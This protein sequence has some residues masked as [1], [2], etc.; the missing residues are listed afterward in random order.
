MGSIL[1]FP[2]R[3]GDILAYMKNLNTKAVNYQVTL[4][5]T[6]AEL[7][8]LAQD[9]ANFEYIFDFAHQM[10]TD[11]ESFYKFK[12]AMFQGPQ[13]PM[14]EAPSFSSVTMPGPGAAGIIARQKAFKARIMLSP[15][16]TPQIGEALGFETPAPI[17]P[18]PVTM[19]PQVKVEAREGGKLYMHCS[20]STADAV[21]W[22][23]QF[24][25]TAGWNFLA[26]TTRAKNV[27][28]LPAS[29]LA[30]PQRLVIRAHYIKNNQP[31]GEYSPGY[32]I[33]TNP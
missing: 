14:P 30:E 7:D 4:A 31:L 13:A 25:E 3:E 5:L 19:T 29:L 10:E 26:D 27:L 8:A 11:V 33:V 2:R 17:P 15:G 23:Y 6:Q 12:K 20:R 16:Y 9:T 21:R 18:D 28:P 1:E 32:T 24:P 22:E